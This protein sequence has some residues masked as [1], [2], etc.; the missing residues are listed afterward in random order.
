LNLKIANKLEA[1]VQIICS[2]VRTGIKDKNQK[3]PWTAYPYLILSPIFSPSTP[4]T[5]KRKL[6]PTVH[7]V[8]IKGRAL[9]NNVEVQNAES[10]NVEKILKMWNSFDPS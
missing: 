6:C 4:V 10:Q 7:L 5:L 8:N 9:R 3:K 1:K 2:E